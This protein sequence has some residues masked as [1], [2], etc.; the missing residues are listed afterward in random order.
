LALLTETVLLYSRLANAILLLRRERSDRL[1]SVEAATAAMA[2][3]IRQPLTGIAALSSAALRWL[4]ATPPNL[5]KVQ[6]CMESVVASA[7]RVDEI[8]SGVRELFRKTVQH[9]AIVDVNDAARRMLNLIQQDLRSNQIS[10]VTEYK[11]D[12]PH[13]HTDRTLLEMAILNLLKN[14]I[15]AMGSVQPDNRRLRL[16]TSLNG[17]S[18]I[19]LSIEDSGPGIAA[20][21]RDHI[22]DT[23][24]TTKPAGTGLGL[25][26]CRTIVEGHGGEVQLT[27]TDSSGSAFEIALPV[28]SHD[29][30]LRPSP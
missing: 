17:N 18:F 20:K 11:D 7:H 22:F 1:V 24:Y 25:S 30:T 6:D 23:L 29:S 9:R 2:H 10:V 14:A 27:K 15:E 4:K 16:V 26:I 12:L 3:E 5:Q 13:V 21:D 28:D 19:S 8:I